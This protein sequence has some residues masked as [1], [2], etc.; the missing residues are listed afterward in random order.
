[1]KFS[2]S[3]VFLC[4]IIN[5]TLPVFYFPNQNAEGRGCIIF[6]FGQFDKAYDISMTDELLNI[7]WGID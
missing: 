6:C 3:N 1:M 5:K 4:T 7:L 2:I